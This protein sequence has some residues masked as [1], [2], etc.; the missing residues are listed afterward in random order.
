M[1][2]GYMTLVKQTQDGTVFTV[3]E[4]ASLVLRYIAD[5]FR[6]TAAH[7][8]RAHVFDVHQNFDMTPSGDAGFAINKPSKWFRNAENQ[9]TWS[10]WCHH[11]S[12]VAS[13]DGD[14]RN[15]LA[16]RVTGSVIRLNCMTTRTST[17][18]FYGF[19]VE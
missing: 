2:P 7:G 16:S 5:V 15:L 11:S 3:Q 19:Q 6:K 17:E 9:R 18:K 14:L 8:E 13:K 12:T 4:T 1:S 10:Q